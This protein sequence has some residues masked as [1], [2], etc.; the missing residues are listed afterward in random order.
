MRDELISNREYT[1]EIFNKVW[2]LRNH[3]NWEQI[4][5][6]I[7]KEYMMKWI[8]FKREKTDNE[9]RNSL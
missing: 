9:S 8:E 5:R 7:G 1:N 4:D 6:F 3:N 2:E